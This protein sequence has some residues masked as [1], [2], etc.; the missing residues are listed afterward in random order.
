MN[1]KDEKPSASGTE[2]KRQ[3]Q[4]ASQHQGSVDALLLL[5]TWPPIKQVPGCQTIS[6]SPWTR[7]FTK[8]LSTQTPSPSWTSVG[9]HWTSPWGLRPAGPSDMV[10]HQGWRTCSPTPTRISTGPQICK[11]P[12]AQ[13]EIKSPSAHSRSWWSSR[14]SIWLMSH[15][16]P[17][18][19]RVCHLGSGQTLHKYNSHLILL[20]L[21]IGCA[22]SVVWIAP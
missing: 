15:K 14:A 18:L 17:P 6:P 3:G 22:K 19:K 2:S 11:S 9:Q 1:C 13:P 16:H 8:S 5:L 7:H 20:S 4:W 12:H 10:T 21:H